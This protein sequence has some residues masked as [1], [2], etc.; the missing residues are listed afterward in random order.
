MG[1]GSYTTQPNGSALPN[2]SAKTTRCTRM[3]CPRVVVIKTLSSQAAILSLRQWMGK[4]C[5]CGSMW[6]DQASRSTLSQKCLS[7]RVAAAGHLRVHVY[8]AAYLGPRDVG[9]TSKSSKKRLPD[10]RSQTVCDRLVGRM[11]DLATSANVGPLCNLQSVVNRDPEASDD[12][13]ERGFGLARH[14]VAPAFC[15]AP[16]IA[17]TGRSPA[18]AFSRLESVRAHELFH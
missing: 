16:C 15:C 6:G 18:S 14:Q 12:A 4:H 9:P 8:L 3:R 7:S 2:R 1:T 13:F 10:E 17:S 11:I 5:A